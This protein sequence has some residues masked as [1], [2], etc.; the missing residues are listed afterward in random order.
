MAC[1]SIPRADTSRFF[2][3]LARLYRWRFHLF[4]LEKNQRQM[5]GLLEQAGIGNSELIEI[6]C[7]IG[8]LH[9]AMLRAGAAR[10]TGIDMSS[11]MLSEARRLARSSD[12]AGR[13]EYREGD[14]VDLA[15]TIPIADIAILDKVICCYPEPERLLK[16]ALSRTRRIIALT[17]PRNRTLTRAGVAIMT[18]GLKLAGCG[19]R[20]YIH[21]PAAIERWI[22][23]E[24]Y[25]RQGRA[26]TFE[27]CTEVYVKG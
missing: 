7:G 6:G 24:G 5:L 19:F 22:C 3:Q 27:W 13:T 4:G 10:A 14:F 26:L 17:Y 9:H 2:S 15:S 11:R 16:L 12:L 18:A 21:N 23:S 20:P 25:R 1:C 8:Y